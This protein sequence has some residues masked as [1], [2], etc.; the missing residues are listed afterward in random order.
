MKSGLV[1]IGEAAPMLSRVLPA[2]TENQI[3]TADKLCRR[4]IARRRDGALETLRDLGS[5]M[6][7]R[8][9]GLQRLLAPIHKQHT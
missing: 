3:G 1:Y 4:S 2:A 9:Q 8:R 5:G 6:N 7:H